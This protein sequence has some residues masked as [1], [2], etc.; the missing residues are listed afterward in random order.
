MKNIAAGPGDAGMIDSAVPIALGAAAGFLAGAVLF[1]TWQHAVEPGQVL[2]G[3]VRY[4]SGNPFA[5]YQQNTYCVLHQIAAL[6]LRAGMSEMAVAVLFS[7]ILGATGFAAVTANIAALAPGRPLLALASP[8]AVLVARGVYSYGVTYPIM[9]LGTA[10]TYGAIGLSLLLL[11]IGLFAVG[12]SAAAAATTVVLVAVH[13]ALALWALL[14]LA[15]AFAI[16]HR[17]WIAEW[18]PAVRGAALGST[19]VATSALFFVLSRQTGLPEPVPEVIRAVFR[20]WDGH[21]RPFPLVSLAVLETVVASAAAG[22][23]LIVERSPSRRRVVLLGPLI[24][25]A[26][27]AT[28]VVYWMNPAHVPAILMALMPSRLFNAVILFGGL[29]S[30]ALFV[31]LIDDRITRRAGLLW[32]TIAS[33]LRLASDWMPESVWSARSLLDLVVPGW[34]AATPDVAARLATLG[35]LVFATSRALALTG[36]AAVARLKRLV[37]LGLAAVAFPA[38]G[39][40]AAGRSVQPMVFGRFSIARTVLIVLV[41]TAGIAA[42]FA[43]RRMGEP[44]PQ[45]TTEG[46]KER[47]TRLLAVVAAVVATVFVAHGLRASRDLRDWRNHPL[48]RSLSRA[49]GFVAVSPRI[50]LVQL[51]TRSRV[52]LSFAGLDFL[53]YAPEAS[54]ITR[55][56]VRRVY[57]IE[58][59]DPPGEIVRDGVVMLTSETSRA[60]WERRSVKEWRD[61]RRELGITDLVCGRDWRLN[62]PRNATSDRFA[63][64]T[65]PRH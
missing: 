49:E 59:T 52:L 29:L 61:L 6:L 54:G 19:V 51:R 5:I 11:S 36:G 38:A 44:R 56:I 15:L 46:G 28:S 23:L 24:L 50:D 40:L 53:P 7:G 57:G 47:D 26:M 65:I 34:R 30:F 58:I 20:W 45:R 18:R 48:W 55:I 62:L 42:I 16:D 31:R 33:F 8:F 60:L 21:R 22:V 10:Y 13:P 2:A 4:P 39:V 27:G 3:L 17:V 12:R 1:P 41:A 35:F 63:H 37:F 25:G 64:Y 9:L 32:L 43:L 14:C